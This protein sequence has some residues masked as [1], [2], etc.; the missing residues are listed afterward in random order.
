M[1][2]FNAAVERGNH[3]SFEKD[4][5][6]L[7]LLKRLGGKVVVI[8][9]VVGAAAAINM[10]SAQADEVVGFGGMGD[11]SGIGYGEMLKA[12][13]QLGP[14]DTYHPVPYPASIWPLGPVT[15]EQS[16]N[17]AMVNANPVLDTARRSASPGEKVV[18]RGYSEGGIAA[19][20]K[21]HEVYGPSVAPGTVVIDGAPVTEAGMFNPQNSLVQSM[22]P[23]MTNMLS[24]PTHDR[25]PAG[26][27]VRGSEQDI[28]FN[29]GPSDL[30]K[31]IGQMMDTFMG[32]A[33]AVQDARGFHYVVVGADGITRHIFPGTGTGGVAP[34]ISM[35][36]PAPVLAPA[37][38]PE[39]RPL[40]NSPNFTAVS[41][42][43]Q[44]NHPERYPEFA[45]KEEAR[46]E[47]AESSSSSQTRRSTS[48][49]QSERKSEKFEPPVRAPQSTALNKRGR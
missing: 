3:F 12:T 41:H 44:R 28:W 23:L 46:T 34:G 16:L 36:G 10:A 20:R 32:P 31:M 11:P 40:P 17:E 21:A 48:V 29:G 33:H 22:M 30:G 2:R 13:G 35:G 25:A 37:P 9:G 27:I 42:E 49:R 24:I 6:K 14:N 15:L 5:N 47:R 43:W 19:A 7:N 26:S 8:A 38:A 4:D 1:A 45:A 18:I 39:A